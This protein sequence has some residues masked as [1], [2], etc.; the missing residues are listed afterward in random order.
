MVVEVMAVVMMVMVAIYEKGI[1]ETVYSM[2]N[3]L[4]SVNSYHTQ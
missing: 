2:R 1:D 4:H 3:I